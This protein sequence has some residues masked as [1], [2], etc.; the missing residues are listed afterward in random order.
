MREFRAL[1]ASGVPIR[2]AGAA[3]RDPSSLLSLGYTPRY[4]FDLFGTT[5][6]LANQREDANFRFFVAFVYQRPDGVR[7]P[8]ERGLF[9][10]IFYKDQS[11]VWRSPTHFI[12]TEEENWIGK[13]AL[14]V[15]IENGE[16]MEFS[17]EETTN[18]PLEIQ[19]A[20]DL[21]T[22]R[23]PKVRRDH[24]AVELVLRRAPAGRFE[25]YSDF[26]TPRR[27]AMSEARNR[28]NRGREIATFARSG[29]P[30]S[31]R[32]VRGYEPDFRK[33][34]IDERR[35]MSRMYDGE[36]RKFR[37]A[38]SN[39][40]IQYQF[41]AAPSQAWIIPPQALTTEISSYGVRTVDVEAAE[42]LCVPGYEYHFLDESEDPPSL[43]SQIPA[44]F[45]GAPAPLDASRADASAWIEKM[46]VI[47]EFRRVLG[48][49]RR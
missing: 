22:R 43:Y 18:L 33:G 38:S 8:N 45:A 28:I 41:V 12:R 25:P 30:T 13:G 16:E 9:P 36:V 17:A 29:D 3:R 20:I 34:V 21:A 24:R 5:F 1:V 31:L 39:R 4:R 32:F 19:A 6:Y 26:S 47:R 44:G 11:L 49:R 15:G 37:I 40:R 42:D 14:K 23:G 27:R 48:L 2:P 35:I 10:R 46:P 7:P